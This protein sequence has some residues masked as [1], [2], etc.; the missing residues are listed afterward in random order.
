MSIMYCPNCKK[1]VLESDEVNYI[2]GSDA[3]GNRGMECSD[4]LCPECGCEL[5]KKIIFTER[6][7]KDVLRHASEKDLRDLL[8]EL[9]YKTK[10]V[11][12]EIIDLLYN[13]Y[14]DCLE[15]NVDDLPSECVIE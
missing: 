10:N 12:E 15:D 14:D 3:D 13:C 9:I 2:Y 6:E 11:K 5:D 4:K 7:F 8:I 1:V